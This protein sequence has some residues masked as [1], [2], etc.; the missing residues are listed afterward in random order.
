LIEALNDEEEEV[1]ASAAAALMG[2]GPKAKAA[3]PALRK[4]LEDN[5]MGVQKAAWNALRAIEGKE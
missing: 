2:H 4:A 3:V 5:K 1:R